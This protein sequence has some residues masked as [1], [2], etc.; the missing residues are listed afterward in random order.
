MLDVIHKCECR[1]LYR[2]QIGKVSKPESSTRAFRFIDEDIFSDEWVVYV[3][4][5]NCPYCKPNRS[6]DDSI[7]YKSIFN[8]DFY[9]GT[10]DIEINYSRI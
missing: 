10:S 3:S 7:L 8:E 9:W 2:F 1:I 6:I 5:E 4:L